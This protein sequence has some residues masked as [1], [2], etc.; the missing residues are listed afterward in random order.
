MRDIG[1][2]AKRVLLQLR[3]D[4][5]TRRILDYDWEVLPVIAAELQPDP[6]VQQ[7]VD[8]WESRAHHHYD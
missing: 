6:A 7:L 5:E 4:P 2:V 8:E 1:R 3:Y